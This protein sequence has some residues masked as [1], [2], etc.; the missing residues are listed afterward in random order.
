M[1]FPKNKSVCQF[2]DDLSVGGM[3]RIAVMLANGLARTGYNSNILCSRGK[4]KLMTQ[5]L[6]GVHCWW[7]NRKSRW[8]I[9]GIIRIAKYIETTGFDIVHTHNHYS[10]YLLRM[11]LCISKHRPLHVVHYHHGPALENKKLTLYDR[12]FLRNTEAHIAVSEKLRERVMKLFSLSGDRCVFIPN[13]IDLQPPQPPWQGEPTVI[14]VASLRSPKSHATAM[15]AAAL[16]RKNIPDLKWICVGKIS[17]QPDDYV[18]E[19]RKLIK[20]LNLTSCVKLTGELDDVRAVLRQAHVGV[21][22]SDSEGLPVALLEYMA[23]QL[24][25]VVTDV[26]QCGAIVKEADSGR[27]V[28]PAD[29]EKCAD[30]IF[31]IFQNLESA[32]KMGR[33]GRSYV[34]K[35]FSIDTMVQG[36]D[37]LYADLMARRDRNIRKPSTISR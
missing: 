8:D 25:V 32:R 2:V 19:V 7:G 13:G 10:S 23:E 34:D 12:L 5:V 37:K 14:Q 24:P 30:A 36:V 31:N 4:G 17:N 3:E 22:T 33:N 9:K 18:N 21:L 26:G 1:S 27:V 35:N 16:L 15:R 11:V 6:P 28:P 29:P 20:E